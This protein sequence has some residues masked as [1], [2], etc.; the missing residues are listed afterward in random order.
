MIRH[1]RP[2]TRGVFALVL[3]L[4]VSGGVR[5][6]SCPSQGASLSS[7]GE[8][9]GDAWGLEVS[10]PAAAPGWLVVAAASASGPTICVSFGSPAVFLPVTLDATGAASLGGILPAVPTLSGTTL[11][12]QA[13]FADPSAAAGVAL[14]RL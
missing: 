12:L 8:R 14:T 5:G 9:L 10:G 6:Q 4:S 3:L 2:L 13:G 1:A 7:F 11:H